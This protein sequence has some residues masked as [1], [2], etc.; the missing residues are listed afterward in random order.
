V[1]T[2]P[3]IPSPTGKTLPVLLGL[4]VAAEE[5]GVALMGAGS[6]DIDLTD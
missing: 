1:R 3:T 5:I 6:V 4:L 2:T